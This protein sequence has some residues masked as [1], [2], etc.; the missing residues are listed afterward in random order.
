M[1]FDNLNMGN[2]VADQFKQFCSYLVDNH[3]SDVM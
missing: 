1:N 2:N 3:S